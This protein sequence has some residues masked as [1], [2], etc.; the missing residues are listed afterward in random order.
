MMGPRRMSENKTI[1]K[2]SY[3][4]IKIKKQLT[5][6]GSATLQSKANI[7]GIVFWQTL[8]LSRKMFPDNLR[9]QPG[10]RS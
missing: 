1:M 4:V 9:I 10:I 7:F 6:K 5:I 2:I 8:K 3:Q